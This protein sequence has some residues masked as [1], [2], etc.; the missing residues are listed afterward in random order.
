MKLSGLSPTKEAREH[1]FS[2][3]DKWA[4]QWFTLELHSL[5]HQPLIRCP[6]QGQGIYCQAKRKPENTLSEE[7]ELSHTDQTD[8]AFL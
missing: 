1:S 6:L 5:C 8:K 2:S 7:K 3:L 4:P